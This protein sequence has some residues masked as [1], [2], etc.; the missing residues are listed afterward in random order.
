MVGI[1]SHNMA[2]S[3]VADLEWR[4]SDNIGYRTLSATHDILLQVLIIE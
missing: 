3:V 1:P 2:S 4:W